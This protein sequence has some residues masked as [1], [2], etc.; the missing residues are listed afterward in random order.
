[1]L[2]SLCI[3]A[4]PMSFAQ[5][6]RIVLH[7]AWPGPLPENPPWTVR[8]LVVVQVVRLPRVL[9]AT[10]AGLGLGISGTALQGMMRNPLVGPDIVGVSSGAAFGGVLAMLFDFSPAGVIALAFCGGMLAIFCTFTLA[11]LAHASSSSMILVLSGIFISGLFVAL[12]DLVKRLANDAQ[13]PT[14]A[15][16]LLGSFVGADPRKVAMIAIPTLGGGAVLMMMRWRLNLLSLG[17]LDAQSLGMNAGFVRWT[18]LALVSLIVASQ[19]AVSGVIGWIGLVVPHCAR[20][21]VGPDHRRLLPVSGLLGALL[22]L[23]LDDITRALIRAEIPSGVM[24][25]LIGTPVVC[26]LFWKAQGKG[27]GRE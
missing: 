17:D 4:Y 15:F 1:M 25:A 5:A 3:G 14:M 21:L 18:I 20:M 7:L 16:W 13:F 19:V 24:T 2:V 23:A 22:M 26:F 8:E 10:L 6:A 12:I 9:L 11:R 27:W